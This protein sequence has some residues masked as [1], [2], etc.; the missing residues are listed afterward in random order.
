VVGEMLA[1]GMNAEITI[2][3]TAGA[4]RRH[5]VESFFEIAVKKLVLVFF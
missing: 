5:L 1:G 3:L 4:G 2:S